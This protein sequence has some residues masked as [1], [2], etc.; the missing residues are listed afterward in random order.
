MEECLHS[1]AE[2]DFT[3]NVDSI[4]NTVASISKN[5]IVCSYLN[6]DDKSTFTVNMDF[7][8]VPFIVVIQWEGQPKTCNDIG[9]L[10]NSIADNCESLSCDILLSCS[11]SLLKCLEGILVA[12]PGYWPW[13]DDGLHY[14]LSL[15]IT[16]MYHGSG[17]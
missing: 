14:Y 3:Y 12:M 9:H 13:Y 17:T 10:Y 2:N 16:I 5:S 11:L 15:L 7:R 6:M 1:N 4:H 8:D